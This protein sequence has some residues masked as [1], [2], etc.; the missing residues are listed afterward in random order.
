MRGHSVAMV[1]RELEING[2][3]EEAALRLDQYYIPTCY[4]DAQPAGA[5]FRYFT[6][7]QSRGA[8]AFA[9]RFVEKAE[10]EMGGSAP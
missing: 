10:S 7:A 4:P 3:L 1:C 5:P 6:A 9:E 2:E 8:L